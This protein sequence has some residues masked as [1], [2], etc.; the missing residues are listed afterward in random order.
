MYFLPFFLSSYETVPTPAGKP[1][2]KH[3]KSEAAIIGPEILKRKRAQRNPGGFDPGELQRPPALRQSNWQ[4]RVWVNF[5]WLQMIDRTGAYGISR[6]LALSLLQAIACEMAVSKKKAIIIG[7]RTWYLAGIL[8]PR[9]R[10]TALSVLRKVPELVYLGRTNRMPF[11]YYARQGPKWNAKF[12][13]DEFEEF[14]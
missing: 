1:T 12:D 5:A 8:T 11:S 3:D 7:P 10:R 6:A 2:M 9:Q 4:P 14:N 13:W